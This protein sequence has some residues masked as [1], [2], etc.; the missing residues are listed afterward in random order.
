MVRVTF[1][2]SGDG[3]TWFHSGPFDMHGPLL[4]ILDDPV[5]GNLALASWMAF[6][7]YMAFGGEGALKPSFH[8]CMCMCC[9]FMGYGVL[10][11]GS[12]LSA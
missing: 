1:D 11:W 10:R 12:W 2:G 7:F 8:S 9:N 3:T 5:G 6:C 4:N